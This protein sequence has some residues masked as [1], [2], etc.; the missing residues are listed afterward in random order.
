MDTKHTP[1]PWYIV[2]AI[3]GDWP[4][5]CEICIDDVEGG[6]PATDY[7]I[8]S[9]VHGDPD[10]LIANARLIAAA[11]ELLEALRNALEL[12]NKV[13]AVLKCLEAGDTKHAVRDAKE[14][15]VFLRELNKSSLAAI[16]KATNQQVCSVA[17]TDH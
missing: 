8:A 4:T 13:G 10:T 7:C 2:D 9:A 14:A 1:A 12:S 17:Y 5:G 6:N 11:P 15:I 16:S 3:N